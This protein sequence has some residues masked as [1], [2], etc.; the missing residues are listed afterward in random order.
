MKVKVSMREISPSSVASSAAETVVRGLP[1]SSLSAEAT[2]AVSI[3]SLPLTL[4]R[5]I[6]NSGVRK[7]A[8]TKEPRVNGVTIRRIRAQMVKG[9]APVRLGFCF[10]SLFFS[11]LRSS[12][13][14]RPN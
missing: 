7:L 2:W 14:L 3:R 8:A 1:L 12:L 13:S 9:P 11:V 6:A 5:S 4:M 10:L